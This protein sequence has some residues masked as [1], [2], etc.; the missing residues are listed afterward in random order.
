MS[1][2]KHVNSGSDCVWIRLW[3]VYTCIFDHRGDVFTEAA[4]VAIFPDP[5]MTGAP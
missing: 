4:R 1:S 2:M 5:G 3:S